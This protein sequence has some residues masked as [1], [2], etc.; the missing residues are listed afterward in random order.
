M[1][2]ALS[3]LEGDSVVLARSAALVLLVVFGL[4]AALVPLYFWLPG[5]YAAASAPVAAL[6]AIMTK[7]GV[8]SIIRVHWGVFGA[9]AGDAALVADWLLPA[10]ADHQRAGRA[11]RAGGATPWGAWWPTSRCR[12]WA[13]SWPAWACSVPTPCRPRCITRCTAPW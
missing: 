8:Y 2:P 6:F 3:Q 12:R 11:G 1:W 10:G 5:T 7:V 4:K 13:P 9:E